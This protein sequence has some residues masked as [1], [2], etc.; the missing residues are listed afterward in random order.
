MPKLQIIRFEQNH[1]K[2]EVL[3]GEFIRAEGGYLFLLDSDSEIL[4]NCVTALLRPIG[5]PKTTSCEGNIDILNKRQFFD[6]AASI[7]Y[8][9]AF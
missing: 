4:P 6:A 8:F 1:G 3:I 2:R 9:G 7:A 5:N